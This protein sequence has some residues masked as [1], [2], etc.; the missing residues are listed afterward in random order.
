MRATVNGVVAA[1]DARGRLRARAVVT[2]A[3]IA[4]A[5][6]LVVY[7]VTRM[8]SAPDARQQRGGAQG[9][10]RTVTLK[11]GD[12]LQ[13]ALE[14]ARPGDTLVLQAGA[15]FVGPFTLP[16]KPGAEFVEVRSSA[17]DRL[18]RE[19]ARVS[20]SDAAAMPKVV[21]PGRG[22]PALRTAP[23]AHHFRFVGVEFSTRDASARAYELIKLGADD[24]TQDSVEKVPHHLVLDRCYVHA[25]PAQSLKRGV[26]LNSAE[27]SVINSHVA[28][29]KVVGQEAQAIAGWNGP[30]PFHVV[31]NYVEA[32]G[33]NLMFGGAGPT[34]PNLVPTD[35]EVRRNH[36]AKD[37]AWFP[38]HRD[39]AGTHWSVK[40]LLEL[41]NARRVNIDGNLF[42]YNW[43][44]AQSGYAI[45]FTPRPNDSG[46]AAV[47]EDVRFTNNIVRHVAAGLH[48]AGQDDLAQDT[49]ARLLRRVVIANNL[50]DDVSGARWDGDG[51]FLKIGR[52]ADQ[53]TVDHNTVL[54]TGNITK[55]WGEP[56]AGFV[57]TNN[58]LSHNEYGVMGDGQSP[59]LRTIETYFPGAVFRGNVFA[60]AEARLYPA[61]NYF[62]PK[63]LDAR[64]KD[65]AVGDFRLL[66]SSPFRGRATDGKDVG[67]DFA[68]LEAA[69]SASREE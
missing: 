52:S 16:R 53:V 10:P 39:F 29:F 35:I 21:S 6:A 46:P 54:H 50:F 41:K 58:L 14:D 31:N 59:G 68:A 24:R 61:G 60:G 47:I 19:G 2:L 25:F 30:G 17:L 9:S 8:G 26:A 55:A 65:E 62:P 45:L 64:F 40:N 12:D 15:V 44:D 11:S 4:A 27:T 42:E 18:P 38:K 33:E 5:L 36:F 56:N 7:A 3:L 23:G 20:P 51:A 43:T 57:F 48:V 66:S 22:E 13:R 63:L 1:R 67:C 28:G 69:S 37:P 34:L 32:A 49:K